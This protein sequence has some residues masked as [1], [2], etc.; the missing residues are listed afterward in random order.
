MRKESKDDR[1][2]GWL[3]YR[4]LNS[5]TSDL[6]RRPKVTAVPAVTPIVFFL[7]GILFIGCGQSGSIPTAT[8]I[9]PGPSIFTV[10][11]GREQAGQFQIVSSSSS[12]IHLLVTLGESIEETT[13]EKSWLGQIDVTVPAMG[14]Y[15]APASGFR[16]AQV[17][18]PPK[19]IVHLTFAVQPTFAQFPA[20]SSFHSGDPELDQIWQTAVR[21]AQYTAQNGIFD[22]PKRDRNV[23]S[24]D[25]Y[26]TARTLRAAFGHASDAL[27]ESSLVTMARHQDRF[28]PGA[29]DINCAPTYNAW[30]ILLMADLYRYNHDL[31]FIQS[32]KPAM[33]F[34]LGVMQSEMQNN[35]FISHGDV[36]ADWSPGMVQSPFFSRATA[37]APEAEKIATMIFYM[38]FNE[39]AFLLSQMGEASAPT[40]LQIAQN[41]K[42]AVIQAYF[43]PVS[44][45]YGPRMQT[46][47]MA[48]YSGLVD[49]AAIRENIFGK[50]LSQPPSAPVSPY[51]N[52][53]VI[54]AM[55]MSGNRPEAVQFVKTFWGSMITTGATTFWESYSP[56]CVN[57]P[58]FHSCLSAYV[59]SLLG[60]PSDPRLVISLC[61]GWSSGAAAFL[62]EV[63]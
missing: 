5:T 59:A 38:G 25:A 62:S 1:I 8:S 10:D 37:P 55:E 9:T 7:C 56:A 43:D 28:C 24:G 60:P 35:L 50:I 26:V 52:Y 14:T 58:D 48:I 27:V 29:Q 15:S 2:D 13:P 44:R 36:F 32:Q 39:A 3:A 42:V 30:W 49:D 16:Y 57:R 6:C 11:F 41:I 22:A 53:F 12:S 46:N 61:H 40:Y 45:T 23:F 33:M 34:L 17:T 54:E 63:Q 18:A 51:F 20:A 47:A 4:L 31:A 19:D 21:T